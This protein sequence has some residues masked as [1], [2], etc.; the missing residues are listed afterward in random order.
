[1]NLLKEKVSGMIIFACFCSV[2]IPLFMV[3]KLSILGVALDVFGNISFDVS[4][5][6]TQKNRRG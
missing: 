1:L 5:T 6:H 3:I 4:T 2:E